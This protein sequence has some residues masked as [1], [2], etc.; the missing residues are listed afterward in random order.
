M[1][2]SHLWDVVDMGELTV[3]LLTRCFSFHPPSPPPFKHLNI[4]YSCIC[5]VSSPGCTI[6]ALIFMEAD[7]MVLIVIVISNL[8]K[9][10]ISK[11][12]GKDD[13][14]MT[15][16]TSYQCGLLLIPALCKYVGWA[17]C[18]FSPCSRVLLHV[19]WCSSLHKN[20]HWTNSKS[21]CG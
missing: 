15:V 6:H 3:V 4:Q 8:F 12:R 1:G 18:W 10:G 16:L 13:T 9:C 17:W 5:H 14:V 2:A 7:H 19:L 21:T 20:Q 11:V